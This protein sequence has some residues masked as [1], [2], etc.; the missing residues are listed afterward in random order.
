[1]PDINILIFDYIF[2]IYSLSYNILEKKKKLN[3]KNGNKE[4]IEKR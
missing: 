3:T 1:M 4:K 2:D